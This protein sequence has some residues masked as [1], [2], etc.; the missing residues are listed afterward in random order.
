ML[1]KRIKKITPVGSVKSVKGSK[2]QSVKS[3]KAPTTKAVK[4]IKHHPVKPTKIYQLTKKT[5]DSELRTVGRLVNAVD[6]R[7]NKV[8]HKEL[9]EKLRG[10]YPMKICSIDPGNRAMGLRIEKLLGPRK[11]QLI[12]FKVIELDDKSDVYETEVI[13]FLRKYKLHL[14]DLIV[15]ER[16]LAINKE[17]IR[18]ECIIRT[19]ILTLYGKPR[20][21]RSRYLIS[22]SSLLKTKF[23]VNNHDDKKTVTFHVARD[24][25]TKMQDK[26]SLGVLEYYRED[27][28]KNKK[29]R[30]DLS[31]TVCQLYALLYSLGLVRLFK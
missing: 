26:D 27:T 3:T 11:T 24:I 7:R 6:D 14:C 13:E 10:N 8:T 12:L 17:M 5:I 2:S 19:A 18:L 4:Y 30:S 20:D 23:M 15:I 9:V 1:G 16:Q 25:L 21:Q 29:P 22:V 28:S 31:D